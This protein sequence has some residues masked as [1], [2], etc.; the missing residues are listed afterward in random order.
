[1]RAGELGGVSDPELEARAMPT[2]EALSRARDRI[3]AEARECECQEYDR[4]GCV[5]EG[6][7]RALEIL[8][9]EGLLQ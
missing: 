8:R 7:D 5:H 6:L 4:A 9:E 1:M 3:D 2:V